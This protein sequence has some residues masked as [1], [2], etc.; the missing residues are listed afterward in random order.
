MLH[1]F[2]SLPFRSYF[3]CGNGRVKNLVSL[4]RILNAA[5]A[6]ENFLLLWNQFYSMLSLWKG[7]MTTPHICLIG[8][9]GDFCRC[10][11]HVISDAVSTIYFMI[12]Q[13]LFCYQFNRSLQKFHTMNFESKHFK[14]YTTY[15]FNG[16]HV[17]KHVM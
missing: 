13:T 10:F 12:L 16:L 17:L 8:K 11:T 14:F 9:H 6:I 5:T 7:K 3:V 2:H 4:M 1:I 15:C